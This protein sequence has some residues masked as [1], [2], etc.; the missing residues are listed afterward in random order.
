MRFVAF[1]RAI[2]VGGHVVKMDRLRTLFEE[3]HLANVETCIASGNVLF[4][5]RAAAATLESR[6]EK[7]LHAALGYDVA[8][9]LR[10]GAELAAVGEHD[11][12]YVGFLKS[13]PQAPEKLLALTPA[14]D[15]LTIDAR[16]VYWLIR[17]RISDSPLNNAKIERALGMPITMRNMNTVRKL[18]AKLA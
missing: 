17:E 8:T 11:V 5:S 14:G 1:L 4:A 15:E 3:L 2:N 12:N 18:A 9:F 7:H 13:E 6:I 16:E 10:T